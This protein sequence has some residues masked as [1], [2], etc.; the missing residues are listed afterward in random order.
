MFIM[1]LGV[2][3]DHVAAHFCST[4]HALFSSTREAWS[5]TIDVLFHSSALEQLCLWF[6]R[7][8]KHHRVSQQA[9]M[10]A[11]TSEKNK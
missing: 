7:P 2:K 1:V 6:S 8:H 3:R 5:P 10:S 9:K 11:E 4:R